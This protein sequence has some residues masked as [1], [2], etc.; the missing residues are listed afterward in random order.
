LIHVNGWVRGDAVSHVPAHD[1]WGLD[2]CSQVIASELI[3]NLWC[4][5]RCDGSA[6][7]SSA[8]TR[9]FSQG[10]AGLLT[11]VYFKSNSKLVVSYAWDLNLFSLLLC[12]GI[13]IYNNLFFLQLCIYI[14]NWTLLLITIGPGAYEVLCR[15]VYPIHLF[16]DTIYSFG[17]LL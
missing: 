8:G 12:V 15:R 11:W 5:M 10:V 7:E 2:H 4:C 17:T 14:N 16:V 13:N 1:H 9:R 3:M 6:R